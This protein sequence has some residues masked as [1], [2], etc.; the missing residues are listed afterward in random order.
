MPVCYKIPLIILILFIYVKPFS[1]SFKDG[2]I[3]S[4]RFKPLF[5][6]SPVC[7]DWSALRMVQSF[8]SVL[9]AGLLNF[10][11]DSTVSVQSLHRDS[12]VQ[13]LL[14]Q[15][16]NNPISTIESLS[17]IKR[18][19]NV[20]YTKSSVRRMSATRLVGSRLILMIKRKSWPRPINL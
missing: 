9:G 17:N 11:T 15:N 10:S 18:S 3:V 12:A 13:S 19:V 5:P 4:C 16:R 2:L 7:C 14:L 6:N 8:A 1:A 20:L